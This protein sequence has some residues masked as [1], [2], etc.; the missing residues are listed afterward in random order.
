MINQ[1]KREESVFGVK[2]RG[3][4]DGSGGKYFQNIFEQR[5][6]KIFLMLK[7]NS[8]FF[9]YKQKFSEFID[10]FQKIHI[11]SL[12]QIKRFKNLNTFQNFHQ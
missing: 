4:N 3:V 6:V 2:R 11:F 12:T 8:I 10:L 1:F 5:F 9:F 7:K